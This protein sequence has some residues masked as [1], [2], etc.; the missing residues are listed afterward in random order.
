MGHPQVPIA[1]HRVIV[2]VSIETNRED[3]AVIKA[4]I[5]TYVLKGKSL[6][7]ALVILKVTFY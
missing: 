2:V 5:Y 1:C 3:C 7:D 6:S 4:L